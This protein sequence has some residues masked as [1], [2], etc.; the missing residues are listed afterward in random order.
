MKRRR[1]GLFLSAALL[2]IGRI[3]A[4]DTVV[5]RGEYKIYILGASNIGWFEAE[6]AAQAYGGHLVVVDDQDEQD[7]LQAN[8]PASGEFWLGITDEGHEGVWKTVTGED[9]PYYH[10]GSGEPNNLYKPGFG[11]EN[12]GAFQRWTGGW[13]ND[14]LAGYHKM[15]GLTECNDYNYDDAC[16][17]GPPPTPT[18]TPTPSPSPSPSPTPVP[19]CEEGDGF[20]Q[21][22]TIT[23]TPLYPYAYEGSVSAGYHVWDGEDPGN[24][25][26]T[27]GDVMMKALA[28]S[29]YVKL[30]SGFSVQGGTLTVIVDEHACD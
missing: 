28:P 2:L 26:I 9:A 21:N 12:V 8:I 27:G 13:W 24:V 23:Q 17:A 6:A 29:G 14:A 18:E 5:R 11:T 3:S 4:A 20:I 22:E 19:A 15:P 7:W 30:D 1:L 16:D 25:I 10:W